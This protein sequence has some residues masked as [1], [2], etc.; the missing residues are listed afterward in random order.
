MIFVVRL[1]TCTILNVCS[2]TGLFP[3]GSSTF[4]S[5][6]LATLYLCPLCHHLLCLLPSSTGDLV[7][8]LYNDRILKLVLLYSLPIIC[9][10][11]PGGGRVH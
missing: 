4:T 10:R 8:L 1:S 3:P 5:A 11:D 7:Q 6:V 2:S 9:W